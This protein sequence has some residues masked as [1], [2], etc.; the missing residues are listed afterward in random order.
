MAEP[1]EFYVKYLDNQAV[2]VRTHALITATGQCVQN[3]FTVGDL[4][5]ALKQALAPLLNDT[6]IAE[7][8]LHLPEGVAKDSLEGDCFASGEQAATIL[9]PSLVLSRLNGLGLDDRSPLVV[10]SRNHIITMNQ[11]L[12]QPV[13]DNYNNQR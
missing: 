1:I 13:Y 2:G 12:T 4:I 9:R 10:K 8:T 5:E 3:I 7:L 6:S 11:Y